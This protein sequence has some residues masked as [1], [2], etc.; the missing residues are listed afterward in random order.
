MPACV[1]ARNFIAVLCAVLVVAG[2]H[3][4]PP[5]PFFFSYLGGLEQNPE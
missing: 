1:D 2:A 5:H 3:H 4:V